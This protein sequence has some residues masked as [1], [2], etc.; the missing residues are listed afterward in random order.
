MA[1]QRVPIGSPSRGVKPIVV[2]T[3]TPAS[4]AHMLA[5]LPR[6]RT[7]VLPLA[8]RGRPSGASRRCTRTKGHGSRSAG[9][10]SRCSAEGSANVCPTVGMLRWNAVSK[11]AICGSC[12]NQSI[13][14][15]I[16][17]RLCGWCRGPSEISVSSFASTCNRF[18]P[19]PGRRR[20]RARPGVPRRPAGAGPRRSLSASP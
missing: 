1:P 2:A 18:A 10:R 9:R 4:I 8:A 19:G 14:L 11:Q 15:R 3:L 5:P 13:R 17:A 16:G 7:T 12:G 6:C 20:R